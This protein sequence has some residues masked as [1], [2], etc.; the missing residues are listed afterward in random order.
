M[1]VTMENAPASAAPRPAGVNGWLV[2][3]SVFTLIVIGLSTLGVVGWLGYRSETQTQ[4]YQQPITALKVKLG[5]GD[6]T[7]TPGSDNTVTVTRRLHWSFRKPTFEERWDGQQL[8]VT[9]NCD[10]FVTPGVFTPGPNCGVDYTL[11]VP[12]GISVQAVTDTGDITVRDLHGPLNLQTSTGDVSDSG[13][14]A[15]LTLRSDTGDV[16]ATGTSAHVDASTDTGNVT[17]HL[18]APPQAV[19][20]QSDTG[21]VMI[22]VPPGGVYKVQTSVD[23]GDANVTVT[24]NDTADRTIT[25][26]TNTGDIG[27]SYA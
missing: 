6:L 25:A 23:T 27:I 22:T 18:T 12:A 19:S 1:T 11:Q 5:T 14:S 8:T 13:A 3:G 4:V 2:I 17:L 20:A 9:A 7:L 16:L 10:G 24:R 26:R 21:D 15:D